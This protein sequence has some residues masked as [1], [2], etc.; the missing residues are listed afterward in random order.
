MP[1]C[2]VLERLRK[3]RGLTQEELGKATGIGRSAIGNYENG[4]RTP[5]TEVLEIF[6]DFFGV[7][8]DTLLGRKPIV[9]EEKKQDFVEYMASRLTPKGREL[10]EKHLVAM[11]MDPENIDPDEV[12]RDLLIDNLTPEALEKRK[13]LAREL[14][15]QKKWA[16]SLE[17]EAKKNQPKTD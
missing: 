11:A 9:K 7:D 15:I 10:L 2:E 3:G 12:V 6:A 5:S 17:R 4:S 8:M 16:K 13:A 1:F 14:R